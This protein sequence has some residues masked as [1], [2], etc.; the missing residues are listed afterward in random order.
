MPDVSGL[1]VTQWIKEDEHLR[2]IPVIAITGLATKEDEEKIRQEPCAFA[3]GSS[4]LV[5]RK[6]ARHPSTYFAAMTLAMPSPEVAI[7]QR[8]FVTSAAC[9]R[10]HDPA[11][12]CTS[13]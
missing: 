11:L 1:Q 7:R 8:F 13:A 9:Y 3:N 4:G 12:P 6:P 10:G 2:H 5:S